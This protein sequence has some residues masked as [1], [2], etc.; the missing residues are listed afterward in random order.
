MATSNNSK[1]SKSNKPAPVAA[2]VAKAAPVAAPAA[3][4]VAK[5]PVKAST[6]PQ[7]AKARAPYEPTQE[8]IQTRAFEIYVSEGC[9]E[10]N[11]L[12]YWVRAEKE[13]RTR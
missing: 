9:K 12:A 6:A 1:S 13:L 4:P 7:P 2:P 3:K 11:D 10:G 8:E 5:P